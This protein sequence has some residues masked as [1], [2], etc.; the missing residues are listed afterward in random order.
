[1]SQRIIIGL[2]SDA[3]WATLDHKLR[4]LGVDSLKAPSADQPDVAVATV[5]AGQDIG[6]FL[7]QAKSLPRVRYAELDAWQSSM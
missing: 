1:M 2:E 7:S 6:A 4:A 3:D 5:P